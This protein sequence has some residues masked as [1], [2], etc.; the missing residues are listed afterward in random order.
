[1]KSEPPLP[2]WLLLAEFVGSLLLGLGVGGAAGAFDGLI[3][4]FEEDRRLAWFT[5][6]AGLVIAAAA[7][8][9]LARWARENAE[10]RR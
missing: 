6:A 5:A 7:L 8:P 1:M 4:A 2:V 9:G 3:T 10:R